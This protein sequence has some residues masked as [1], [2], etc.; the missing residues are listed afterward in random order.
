MVT[1]LIVSEPDIAS[2]I[3]GDALLARGGWSHRDAVEGG[4]VWQHECGDVWLWWFGERFLMEDELDAISRADKDHLQFLKLFIS[5][6]NL[7]IVLFCVW[8]RNI[9]ILLFCKFV[10]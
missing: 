4:R 8:F 5:N 6:K 10:V 2:T 7:K 3:Q 1:L 9:F